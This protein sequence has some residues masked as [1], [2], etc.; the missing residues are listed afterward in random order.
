MNKKFPYQLLEDPQKLASFH[1]WSEEVYRDFLAFQKGQ[2]TE[3]AFNQ[4]YLRRK[5][6]LCLDM[7]GFTQ[8]AMNHGSLFSLLRIFDVQKVCAP[9]FQQYNASRVR[10][11]ADDFTVLFE[12]PQDALNSALEVHRRILSFNSSELASKSPA[13]CCIGIGYGDVY[14]I[15][16]DMAMGDEMNRASKLGEDTAKAQ[17]TLIT[18]GLYAAVAGNKECLFERVEP[19]TLPFGYYKVTRRH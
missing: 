7:T 19:G 15:G 9:V 2:L 13:S 5:A 18:E 8:S 14:A 12:D 10:A 4:K 11:F 1:E 3:A 16:P 6:I 17:E